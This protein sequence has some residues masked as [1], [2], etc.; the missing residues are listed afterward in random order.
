MADLL[1]SHMLPKYLLGD[2][3]ISKTAPVFKYFYNLRRVTQNRMVILKKRNSINSAM[4]K[5][6]NM[7]EY[8]EVGKV[9]IDIVIGTSFRFIHSADTY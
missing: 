6:C 9:L 2:T 8:Y 5:C 3:E 4:V 1:P 7:V